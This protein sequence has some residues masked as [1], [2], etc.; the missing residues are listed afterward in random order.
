M[1]A[2]SPA[3]IGNSEMTIQTDVI[4]NELLLLSKDA[5]K[6]ANT[7]TDF[8]NDKINI[9]GQDNRFTTSGH[10]SIPHK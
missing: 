8:T 6:K 4:S 10:Y 7:K 9:L 2:I 1:S 3:K 5:I